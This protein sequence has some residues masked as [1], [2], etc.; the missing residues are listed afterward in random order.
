MGRE[1][2]AEGRERE[3]EDEA[4]SL[5]LFVPPFARPVV[6]IKVHFIFKT[7]ANAHPTRKSRPKGKPLV[8]VVFVQLD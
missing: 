5:E 4:G 2:A 8:N 7:V 1:G 3:D 6:E